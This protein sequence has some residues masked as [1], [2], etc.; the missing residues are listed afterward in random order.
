MNAFSAQEI[1]KLKGIA[2]YIRQDIISM[3]YEAGSGHPG[4][5][6]GM[7]DIITSLYFQILKH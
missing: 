5:S 2:A 4:G 3:I 6:L 7:A 1:Q